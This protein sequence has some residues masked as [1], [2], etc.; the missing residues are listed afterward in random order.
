MPVTVTLEFD[1][2]A[3]SLSI[4]ADAGQMKHLITNLVTNGAEAVPEGETGHIRVTTH[5]EHVDEEYI[6]LNAPD[7]EMLPGAFAVLGIADS[8][9]GMDP[10]TQ[11]RI[12]DPFFT[13]KF[14]GRGLGLAA[15]LGIVKR[16]RGSILV[17]SQP[18]GGTIFK[19]YLPSSASRNEPD[20]LTP[21][22]K[23]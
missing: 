10:E 20:Q 5:Q 3:D 12:F 8:G 17:K 1:L 13:T 6:R 2:A 22:P 7:G 4:E 18:G 14:T 23:D 16:H 11:A 9:S 19:I 21:G 15:A